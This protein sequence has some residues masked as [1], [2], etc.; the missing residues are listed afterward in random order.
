[1]GKPMA[2]TGYITISRIAFLC[3]MPLTILTYLPSQLKT[4]TVV[5]ATTRP[6]SSFSLRCS[7]ASQC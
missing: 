3:L 2:T 4:S 5:A 1:M 6:L 7:L